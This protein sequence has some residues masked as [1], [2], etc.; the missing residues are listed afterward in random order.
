MCL[1]RGDQRAQRTTITRTVGTQRER[2]APIAWLGQHRDRADAAAST[3]QTLGWGQIG[4][5]RGGAAGTF[6]H[7]IAFQYQKMLIP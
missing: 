6:R 7:L 3:T 5:G 1:E 2:R 4:I